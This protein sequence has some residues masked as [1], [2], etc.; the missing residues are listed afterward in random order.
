MEYL[1]RTVS[2]IRA[3]S[4]EARAALVRRLAGALS[5]QGVRVRGVLQP[6][7][8]RARAMRTG[9]AASLTA[10]LARLHKCIREETTCSSCNSAKNFQD[11]PDN[12]SSAIQKSSLII[13]Q[14]SS[15]ALKKSILTNSSKSLS[16]SSAKSIL[17]NP[18]RSSYSLNDVKVC[19]AFLESPIK[20][21]SYSSNVRV[22]SKSDNA[23]Q[24]LF[25]ATVS[26]PY[27]SKPVSKSPS[28]QLLPTPSSI[29]HSLLQADP[30]IIQTVAEYH[31]D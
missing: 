18:I 6:P 17:S 9:T 20:H 3:I 5:Q 19:D 26:F 8:T 22:S 12:T 31:L 13:V 14:P 4:C 2:R 27:K 7:R 11:A 28:H 21:K 23:L 1:I 10:F 25:P 16:M 30:N 15:N 29:E 24:R